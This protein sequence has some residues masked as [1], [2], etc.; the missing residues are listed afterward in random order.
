MSHVASI[1]KVKMIL[2]ILVS[3]KISLILPHIVVERAC[4]SKIL[5]IFNIFYLTC[6][7]TYN[8][9]IVMAMQIDPYRYFAHPKSPGQ[10]QYEALRA[11]YVDNLPARVVADRFGYTVPSFNALKQKFKSG[12]LSFKFTEKPG[13]Q[14]SRLPKE[15]QQ[16]IF[17]IRRVYSLSSY[18]IAEILAIEG[19]E[20]NPR[21]INR[22]LEKAGFPP[23]P[24]RAKMS[25][26]E[27]VYGAKVPHEAQILAL[28]SLEGRTVE[29]FA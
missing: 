27:T 21:T 19:F 20:V 26:G 9:Y 1:A 25:I 11:F 14:G 5:W 13:P 24:R 18:R 4:F 10:K 29:T 12:K 3:M 16:R 22:L 23:V 28:E 8:I 2:S 17:D 6:N 15:I 7:A